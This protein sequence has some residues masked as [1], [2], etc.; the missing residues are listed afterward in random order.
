MLKRALVPEAVDAALEQVCQRVGKT[1]GG[2]W[3][4]GDGRSG[5]EPCLVLCF[6]GDQDVYYLY[7]DVHKSVMKDERRNEV[8][9]FTDIM[10]DTLLDK[11]NA[12]V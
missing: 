5:R 6:Y 7:V 1:Y 12:Q 4:L 9:T 3:T 2:S 11:T 8:D 10:L